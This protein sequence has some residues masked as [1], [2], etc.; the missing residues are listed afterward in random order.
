MLTDP[1]THMDIV[2]RG[3][4]LAT[5][6][7]PRKRNRKAYLKNLPNQEEHS[8]QQQPIHQDQLGDTRNDHHHVEN[9]RG[10]CSFG[11]D[12]HPF[13]E[14]PSLSQPRYDE[15]MMKTLKMSKILTAS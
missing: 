13:L 14:Q 7:E 2:C 8:N 15:L 4:S 6:S 3:V 1:S 5:T 11:V 9:H 12:R 10:T